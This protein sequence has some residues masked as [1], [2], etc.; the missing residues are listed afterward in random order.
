MD[1]G[2]E[3]RKGEIKSSSRTMR[4]DVFKRLLEISKPLIARV[5]RSKNVNFV[6]IN[7]KNV[8]VHG[9]YKRIY[10]SFCRNAMRKFVNCLR[11]LQ[12]K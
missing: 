11:R 5:R 6:K 4:F 2:N 12:R 7:N 10:Y 9:E 3:C 1:N 8:K